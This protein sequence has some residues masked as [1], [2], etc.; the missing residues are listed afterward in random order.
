[1]SVYLA[2]AVKSF[3]RSLAY[4][5]A[6]LAGLATNIFFGAVYVYVYIA[7]FHGRGAVGGLDLRDTIT[8]AVLTQSLLMVMTAFGNRDL[9]E[10]VVKGDIATDLSR[11]VDFYFFWAA[12]DLGRAVYYLFFRGLPTFAFC[13]LLFRPELPATPAAAAACLG[14]L[15]L[16]TAISFAFRF[17][18]SSL[19]FWFSDVRGLNYLSGTL[20]LF[21]S[22]FIV[23]LN[24][25][26][27]GLRTIVE[28]LPFEA[29]AH[30]PINIYLGKI[31]GPALMQAAAIDIAWL[32]VMIVAGR[33]VLNRMVGRL[34]VAGG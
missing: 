5:A 30:L 3:Q 6:N 22:G 9:S 10:A 8:Y 28:L 32:I 16:G 14:V 2:V 7:L 34:T 29:L 15:L 12:Q 19:A 23:P 26:P 17:I 31:G 27:T 20:I 13:M 4:R 1:M 11:P 24:F 25:L 33:G 21:F 18:I